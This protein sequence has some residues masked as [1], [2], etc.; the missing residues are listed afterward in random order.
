[1]AKENCMTVLF[2][3]FEVDLFECE[4]KG[5]LG[6]TVYEQ[7]KTADDVDAMSTDIFVKCEKKHMEFWGV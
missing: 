2:N 3:G 4:N 6:I 1:M 5:T 7:G